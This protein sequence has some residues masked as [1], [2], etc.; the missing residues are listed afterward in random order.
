VKSIIVAAFEPFGGRRHNRSADAAAHLEGATIAGHPVEVARLPVEFAR[1][2]AAVAALLGRD[3]E[4]L[5]LVGEARRARSLEVERLAINVAHAPQGDNAGARPV[6]EQV[7]RGGE[8][9]R[10]V[11]FDPRS[12]SNAAIA[13]GTPCTVSA[14]AGTFCC[15]AALYHALGLANARREPPTVA[16][17]HV[18]SCW[19]W[20]RDRRA[21][22][23]LYAVAA[24]LV[25][26]P[27]NSH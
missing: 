24:A 14:H 27:R 2:E 23:G 1:L 21:A 18:P 19:P 4:L 13:A 16:F 9:A 20:A 5:L 25:G 15:N 26:T 6:D 12:A 17:I 22:R 8:L 11:S 10:H 3:P 7:V